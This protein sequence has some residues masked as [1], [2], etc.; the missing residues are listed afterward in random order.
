MI[1]PVGAIAV[2]G[3]IGAIATTGVIGTGVKVKAY[4]RESAI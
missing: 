3:I 1:V 4:K 2:T